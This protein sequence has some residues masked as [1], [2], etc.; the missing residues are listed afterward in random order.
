MTEFADARLARGQ[1]L[2]QE[3]LPIHLRVDA[4]RAHQ[5]V[6]RAAFDDAAAIEDDDQIGLDAPSRRDGRR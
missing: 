4:I 1:L 2:L 5:L 6:V 3:L